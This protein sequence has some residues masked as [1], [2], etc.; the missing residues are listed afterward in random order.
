MYNPISRIKP[1]QLNIQKMLFYLKNYT[2]I[3][4]TVFANVTLLRYKNAMGDILTTYNL[5]FHFFKC[6]QV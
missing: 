5:V 1:T 4:A 3:E 6:V 2:R